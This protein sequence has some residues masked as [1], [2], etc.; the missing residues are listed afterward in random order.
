MRWPLDLLLNSITHLS[1]C[2]LNVLCHVCWEHRAVV[3][4]LWDW[5]FPCSQQSFH[6]L[7]GALIHDKV[8]VHER[9][10]HV[11]TKIDCVRRAD[12]LDD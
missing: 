6:G 5:L 9:S 1:E 8:R 11:T 4:R 2:I 10:I 12:V 7:A 3:Q